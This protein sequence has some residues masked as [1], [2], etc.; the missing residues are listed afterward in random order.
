MCTPGPLVLLSVECPGIG[1][2]HLRAHRPILPESLKLRFLP[3]SM[4]CPLECTLSWFI[5]KVTFQGHVL[6]GSVQTV[7]ALSVVPQPHT[8]TTEAPLSVGL[9]TDS[10]RGSSP[11]ASPVL[12][13]SLRAGTKQMLVLSCSFLMQ[14]RRAPEALVPQPPANAVLWR[15]QIQLLDT[16][17][18]TP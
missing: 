2:C 11:S 6:W 5:L 14:R 18:P 16:D 8:P 15:P 12:L 7:W 4:V 1:L 13:H 9:L 17:L 3:H 10:C